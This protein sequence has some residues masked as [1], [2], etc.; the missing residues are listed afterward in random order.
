MQDSVPLS[1]VLPATRVTKL[2]IP[3]SKL[4]ANRV[5]NKVWNSYGI[6]KICQCTGVHRLIRYREL[7]RERKGGGTL[8]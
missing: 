5:S 6:V 2:K 4:R 8:R 3:E 7:E 1:T